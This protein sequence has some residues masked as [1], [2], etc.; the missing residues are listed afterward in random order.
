MSLFN[1]TQL[2]LYSLLALVEIYN[3]QLCKSTFIWSGLLHWS[4]MLI[5]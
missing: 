2:Y 5:S 3:L 1:L 4:L